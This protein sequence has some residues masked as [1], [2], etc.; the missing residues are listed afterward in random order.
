MTTQ[1][2]PFHQHV[3]G[4]A[5]HSASMDLQDPDGHTDTN[6]CAWLQTAHLPVDPAMALSPWPERPS[7][8]APAFLLPLPTSLHAEETGDVVAI[9]CQLSSKPSLWTC[10]EMAWA[11]Q[12]GQQGRAAAWIGAHLARDGGALWEKAPSSLLLLE[13]LWLSPALRV[14]QEARGTTC[15][16]F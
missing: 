10:G 13:S 6:P 1:G 12:P 4:T 5:V 16:D 9:G 15:W 3:L 2:W 7:V 8:S 14:G 11:A